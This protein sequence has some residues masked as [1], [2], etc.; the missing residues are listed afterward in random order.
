[1][2][3]MA[4]TDA[5]GRKTAF[6]HDITTSQLTSIVSPDGNRTRFAYN[7]HGLLTQTILPDDRRL[8]RSYD[9]LGRL[10]A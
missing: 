3:L 10:T 6:T 4:Q 1:Y 2:L 5:L 9:A 8:T 7:I